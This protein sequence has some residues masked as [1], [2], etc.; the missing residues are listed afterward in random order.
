MKMLKR[1]RVTKVRVKS[2]LQ[3]A[4]KP[5]K[6]KKTYGKPTGKVT[7]YFSDIEVAVIKLSA[8]LSQGDEIRIMGG[9]STDFNQVVK[10]MQVDHAAIKKA[11]KGSSVGIK[12]S[13][14]VRDGY[15]V[16]KI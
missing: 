4:K 6:I 1:K 12:I 15:K 9:E 3:K 7:H 5:L 14:K 11:K 8:P 13:E 10:S 16:Y 2:Q